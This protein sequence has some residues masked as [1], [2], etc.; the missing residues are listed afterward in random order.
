LARPRRLDKFTAGNQPVEADAI[1]IKLAR[2]HA[3]TR[4]C[5]QCWDCY[6]LWKSRAG[7]VRRQSA[8]W[9]AKLEAIASATKQTLR[10]AIRTE[11]KRPGHS[12]D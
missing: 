1:F 2:I 8:E 6:L 5:T 10:P 3:D 9:K 7:K 11:G 12:S 4:D